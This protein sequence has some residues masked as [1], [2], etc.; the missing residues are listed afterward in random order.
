MADAG[1]AVVVADAELTPSACAREVDALLG[2]RA[3]LAAMG[4]ASAGWRGRTPRS[5]SRRSCWRPR[6]GASA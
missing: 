5:G 1:A 2:D 6:D 4:R 3:R